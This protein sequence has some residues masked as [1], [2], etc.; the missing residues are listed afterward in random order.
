MLVYES[1]AVGISRLLV[2]VSVY[3]FVDVQSLPRAGGWMTKHNP[4]RRYEG[5]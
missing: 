3:S 1:D 5:I 2:V 4:L